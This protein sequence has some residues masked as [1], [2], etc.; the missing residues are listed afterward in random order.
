MA[1]QTTHHQRDAFA[2]GKPIRHA[3]ESLV[4]GAEQPEVSTMIETTKQPVIRAGQRSPYTKATR[5]Q[6]IQREEVASLLV[7]WGFSKAETHQV[8][9]D[10][11]GIEWRQ[12][13]R[14]MARA[15]KLTK[16]RAQGPV[17]S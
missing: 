14:Y 8:F 17:Q 6:M 15:R 16:E 13:D 1:S 9:R 12:T 3:N 2:L 11:Y 7:D 5:L 4:F 10:R